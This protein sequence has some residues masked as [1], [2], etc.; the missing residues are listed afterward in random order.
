MTAPASRTRN[1]PRAVN[2]EPAA[3]VEVP[4]QVFV[5]AQTFYVQNKITNEAKGKADKARK[6]LFAALSRLGINTLD[7]PANIDGQATMLVATVAAKPGSYIDVA[8]LL[9]VL[10]PTVKAAVDAL[11]GESQ[12]LFYALL[13]ASKGNTEDKAGKTVA[14]Q[15]EKTK[16]GEPNAQVKIKGE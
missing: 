16:M 2:V 10:F 7:V 6:S 13:S 15:A 5:D 14:A 12:T 1:Q 3:P 9:S 8:V 11:P 4:A